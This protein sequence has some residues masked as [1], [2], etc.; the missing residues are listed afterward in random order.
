MTITIFVTQTS[1]PSAPTQRP[2]F[3]V[4]LKRTKGVSF[5]VHRLYIYI[6]FHLR[7]FF[8]YEAKHLRCSLPIPI[9]EPQS[10]FVYGTWHTRERE[11]C[12]SMNYTMNHHQSRFIK[13]QDFFHMRHMKAK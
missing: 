2:L 3:R 4:Q 7:I 12:L 1:H 10:P 8:A 11:V 13:P 6:A 5:D 9:L